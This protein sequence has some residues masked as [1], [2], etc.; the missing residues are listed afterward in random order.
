MDN[1][2]RGLATVRS[3]LI[4]EAFNPSHVLSLKPGS[5]QWPS[6]LRVCHLPDLVLDQ[7]NGE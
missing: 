3:W 4:A 5:T 2:A 7:R 6:Y 1:C